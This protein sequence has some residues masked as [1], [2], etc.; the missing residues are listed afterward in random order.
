MGKINYAVSASA[1]NAVKPSGF[2]FSVIL[3]G[4][5]IKIELPVEILAKDSV[6]T[7]KPV[8]VI[9]LSKLE[10]VDEY[11]A[12]NILRAACSVFYDNGLRPSWG[13]LKTIMKHLYGCCHRHFGLRP[14]CKY[15]DGF[16]NHLVRQWLKVLPTIDL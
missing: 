2:F 13:E 16:N 1:K 6:P 7:Y 9:D 11:R 15:L 3:N 10:E 4:E 8:G 14:L 5:A 12:G